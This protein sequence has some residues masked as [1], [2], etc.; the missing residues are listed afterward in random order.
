MNNIKSL[1]FSII[2]YYFDFS[3]KG[4]NFQLKV[5]NGCHDVLM[6]SMNLGDI[7]ILDIRGVDYRSIINGISKSEAMALFNLATLNEK[8]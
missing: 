8:N 6:M 7:A 1:C 4:F 2:C 3:E 5:C